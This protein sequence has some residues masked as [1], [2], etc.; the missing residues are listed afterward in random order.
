MYRHIKIPKQLAIRLALF[1]GLMGGAMLFDY[2]FD[3]VPVDIAHTDDEKDPAEHGVIYLI[4]QTGPVTAKTLVQRD[5]G[6]R[7][8]DNGHDRFIQKYHG[9]INNQALISEKTMLKSPL[10]LPCHYLVFRHRN[11]TLP[12][13]E[14]PLC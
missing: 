4:N 14:P 11:F 10:F 1:L 8:P 7:M 3:E 13:D 12:D 5:T 6:R 2:F 9:T